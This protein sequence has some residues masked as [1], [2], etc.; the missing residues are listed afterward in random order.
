MRMSVLFSF[1]ALASGVGVAGMGN[2]AVL[3]LDVQHFS[4]SDYPIAGR[5]ARDAMLG[6][7]VLSMEDFE[8]Q[9]PAREFVTGTG[10]DIAQQSFDTNTVGNF[11][12]TG[13]QGSGGTVTNGGPLNPVTNHGV[14]AY[15]RD[16]N[17]Y[18]RTNTTAGGSFHLDSN[19]VQNMAWN[20]ALAGDRMFD[21]L[22]FNIFDAADV[23]S[24]FSILVDGITY[25]T[26][27]GQR[28][29]G[30]V[31]L[32]TIVFAHKVRATSI[33]FQNTIH[34]DGFGI[35]DIAIGITPPIPVPLPAGGMLLI[36]SLGCLAALKRLL[37]AG[38]VQ[39]GQV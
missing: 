1:L 20:V 36:M 39:A 21:R 10:S 28:M 7:H 17:T 4:F 14:G 19:D 3:S 29:N 35:D 32:V 15:L 38:R 5:A 22:V 12:M 16:Q 18:G 31:S 37:Y 30:E 13:S 33:L 2:A 6:T 11:S 27:A 9:G 34:N 23:G 24:T 26:S 8:H 25:F